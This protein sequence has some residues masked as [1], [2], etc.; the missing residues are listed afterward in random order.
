MAVTLTRFSPHRCLFTVRLSVCVQRAT[1]IVQPTAFRASVG[2]FYARGACFTRAE[3]CFSVAEPSSRVRRHVSRARR[4]LSRARACCAPSAGIFHRLSGCFAFAEWSSRETSGA[5]GKT[6]GVH[7]KGA[8]FTRNERCSLEMKGRS[9]QR[10]R[11]HLGDWW[12]LGFL[13]C[14]EHGVGMRPVYTVHRHLERTL[15]RLDVLALDI[16]RREP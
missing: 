2:P 8:V 3:T 1:V 7:E 6:S 13:P 11:A 14:V 12:I 5:T 9:R 15:Q 16:R 4:H 10:T